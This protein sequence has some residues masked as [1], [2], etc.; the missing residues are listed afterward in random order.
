MEKAFASTLVLTASVELLNTLY[1][2][3]R[4]EDNTLTMEG[5]QLWGQS[6]SV[7]SGS[8]FGTDRLSSFRRKYLIVHCL[9]SFSD[10]LQVS[11]RDMNS[12]E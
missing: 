10:F 7:N 3:R 6:G 11:P 4:K 5:V 8:A 12:I 1:K 2:N 9:A